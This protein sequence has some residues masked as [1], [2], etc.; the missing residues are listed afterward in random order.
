MSLNLEAYEDTRENA[1]D[2]LNNKFIELMNKFQ[3][4]WNLVGANEL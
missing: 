1:L 2:E 3:K 4:D